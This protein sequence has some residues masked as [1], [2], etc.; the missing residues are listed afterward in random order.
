MDQRRRRGLDRR[1]G[2]ADMSPQSVDRTLDTWT[3]QGYPPLANFPSPFN[4]CITPGHSLAPQTDIRAE[5]DP[6]LGR[7]KV[8]QGSP[9][10]REPMMSTPLPADTLV[11][12]RC[13][14]DVG[15]PAK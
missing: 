1:E 8:V 13:V 2:K 9:S 7:S 11:H 5:T 14:Y 10:G 12:S 6:T 15:I 4:S 3:V